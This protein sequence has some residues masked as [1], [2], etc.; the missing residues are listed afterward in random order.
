MLFRSTLLPVQI[1]ERDESEENANSLGRTSERSMHQRFLDWSRQQGATETDADRPMN[2]L[3]LRSV[4][5]ET[6]LG[7]GATASEGERERHGT[8]TGQF[9][10]RRTTSMTSKWSFGILGSSRENTPEGCSRV[11]NEEGDRRASKRVRKEEREKEKEKKRVIDSRRKTQEWLAGI[12]MGDAAGLKEVKK[13]WWRFRRGHRR[14]PSHKPLF[15]SRRVRILLLVGVALVGATIALILFFTLSR[16]ESTIGTCVCEN[17]GKA[18]VTR[19]ECSCVCRGDW[20]GSF[21]HL[22]TTCANPSGVRGQTIA[23]GLLD[24]AAHANTLFSPAIDPSRLAF[25]V[26]NYLGI[27]TN[28]SRTTCEAQLALVS[29]PHLPPS[30]FANRLAWTSAAVLW[31]AAMS[32]SNATGLLGF[33]N[34]KTFDALGDVAT[35]PNSNFQSAFSVLSAAN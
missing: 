26:N 18:V 10:L 28:A 30:S 24:I 17:E 34:S 32:E 15:S 16:R 27:S 29:L 6:K 7:R 22:D 25:V 3:L 31:S 4:G 33:A 12:S 35:K 21:C 23:Q 13:P 5:V 2:E 1:V 9:R 11:A 14:R 20:G 19:G 8:S